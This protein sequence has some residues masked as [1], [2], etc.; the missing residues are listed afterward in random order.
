MVNAPKARG[1]AVETSFVRYAQAAGFPA[2]ERRPLAGAKDVGDV[3]LCRRPGMVIVE[4]K[5]A[6]GAAG[7]QLVPWMRET[8]AE[9]TNS[10]LAGEGTDVAFL[11]A[12]PRGLGDRNVGRWFAAVP[13]VC[14][15]FLSPFLGI[16]CQG[17]AARVNSASGLVDGCGLDRDMMS[18]PGGWDRCLLEPRSRGLLRRGTAV[19][20]NRLETGCVVGPVWWVLLGLRASGYGA[21]LPARCG[22]GL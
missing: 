14:W 10:R 8:L 6:M 20:L 1:T 17:S 3:R 18:A 7:V 13:D 22:E 11:V 15:E 16:E 21:V 4:C 5:R 19:E 12:K 9:L 2:A